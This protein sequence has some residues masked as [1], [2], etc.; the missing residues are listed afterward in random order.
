ML[1]TQMES[2]IPSRLKDGV[3]NG[4]GLPSGRME[5]HYHLRRDEALVPIFT[6]PIRQA[7]NLLLGFSLSTLFLSASHNSA[8]PAKVVASELT[9]SSEDS[10]E[11]R[12]SPSACLDFLRFIDYKGRNHFIRRSH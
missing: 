10:K 11:S 3:S 5:R 8:A 9:G 4:Y 6:T 1:S 2:K 7:Y 12:T